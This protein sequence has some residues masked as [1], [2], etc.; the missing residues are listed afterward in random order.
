MTKKELLQNSLDEFMRLQKYLQLIQDKD[1]DIYKEVKRRYNELKVIL[2]SISGFGLSMLIS[3][4]E[5]D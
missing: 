1:L 4:D 2:N 3:I 5:K